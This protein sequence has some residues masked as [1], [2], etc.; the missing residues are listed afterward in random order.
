MQHIDYHG[1]R[2]VFSWRLTRRDPCC[3]S[4]HPVLLRNTALVNIVLI[5]IL[6]IGA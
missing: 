1:H 3:G 4:Y 2:P 5:L 6:V